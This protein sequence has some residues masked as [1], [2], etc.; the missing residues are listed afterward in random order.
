MDITKWKK[1][2]YARVK[3]DISTSCSRHGSS[4]KMDKMPGKK[5]KILRIFEKRG[6]PTVI[7]KYN[8]DHSYYFDPGDLILITGEKTP[9]QEPVL[10]DPHQLVI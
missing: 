7:L 6:N 5:W 3:P 8:Y 4:S 1:G 10:F 9:I 2:M